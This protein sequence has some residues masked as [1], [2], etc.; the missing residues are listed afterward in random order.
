M[1][2]I[3]RKAHRVFLIMA[4]IL[5]CGLLNLGLLQQAHCAPAYQISGFYLGATPDD[6]G[7]T[8]EI[9]PEQEE[10]YYEVEVGGVLLF[11]IKVQDTLRLYRIVKEQAIEPNKVNS[12]LNNLKAQYGMPDKQQIKTGSVRPRNKRAYTTTVKNKAIWNISETQEFIAEIE[13][14]RA[15]YELLDNSPENIK[16]PESTEASEGGELRT[17]GWNPDY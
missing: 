3:T 7:V 15:V 8:V 4:C 11:F 13:R 9:D 2:N 10:K 6:V 12:V 17:E 5:C 1:K 14:K 16:S